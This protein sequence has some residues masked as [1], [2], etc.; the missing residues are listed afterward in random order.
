MPLPP[1]DPS[2]RE[3]RRLRRGR[4]RRRARVSALLLSLG[5]HG[6]AIAAAVLPGQPPER[7]AG[8]GPERY[9]LALG[10]QSSASL[11]S[12]EAA[13]PR[14]ELLEFEPPQ[15]EPAPSEEPPPPEPEAAEADWLPSPLGQ[16]PPL[17][18]ARHGRPER[19]DKAPRTGEQADPAPADGAASGAPVADAAETP[20]QAEPAE[21]AT[22]APTEGA[23]AAPSS[24]A[25]GGAGQPVLL[26]A[27]EPVYPARAIQLR[28]QGAVLVAVRIAADGRVESAEVL[29]SSSFDLLDRAALEAI[30]RWR[31]VPGSGTHF[32][33][34]FRFE[35]ER[36][37]QR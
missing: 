14:P 36:S 35:L 30:Q 18:L 32:E 24:S 19:A 12:L 10:E 26:E 17:D 7:P 11:A 6:A 34:R 8:R 22:P 27:P 16:Q 29:E 21:P 15:A 13:P 25:G 33:H 20:Q 3:L 28:R 37:G 9:R 5:L 1:P 2:A 31:F 4:V 23:P